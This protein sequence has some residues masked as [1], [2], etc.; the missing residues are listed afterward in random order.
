MARGPDA[1]DVDAWNLVG[2]KLRN[3]ALVWDDTTHRPRPGRAR[4]HVYDVDG[5]GREIA[6]GSVVTTTT[7]ALDQLPGTRR[8]YVADIIPER[9]GLEIAW[10]R[11]SP[12]DQR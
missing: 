12:E 4:M 1:Y 11:R 8:F 5:D 10:I 6:L 3:V 2:G 7:D 9:P